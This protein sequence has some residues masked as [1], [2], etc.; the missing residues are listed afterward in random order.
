MNAMDYRER[1]QQSNNWVGDSRSL[2]VLE[3]SDGKPSRWVLR[4]LGV[5]NGPLATRRRP[6]DAEARLRGLWDG[7]QVDLLP[8]RRR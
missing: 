4:G 7:R 3:P 8:V 6:R 5:G 1:R 2:Q